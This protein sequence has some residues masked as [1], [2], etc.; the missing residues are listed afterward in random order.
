ML[1]QY[2][3]TIAEDEKTDKDVLQML[4]ED[5]KMILR[6]MSDIKKKIDNIYTWEEH[7]TE[8]HMVA[9]D[10][11]EEEL[12]QA[13]LEKWRLAVEEDWGETEAEAEPKVHVELKMFQKNLDV[14]VWGDRYHRDYR[15][16]MLSGH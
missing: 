15:L 7:V 10:M 6:E 2:L 14:G 11:P 9:L 3:D 5:Q 8:E 16:A 4:K 12:G 13:R 1:S